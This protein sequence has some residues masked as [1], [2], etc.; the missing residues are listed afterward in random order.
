M[1]STR[2]E[3]SP[4]RPNSEASDSHSNWP[5]PEG[6]RQGAHRDAVRAKVLLIAADGMANT[7]IGLSQR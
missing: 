1:L 4:P 2:H 3:S 5:G 6:S 7:A